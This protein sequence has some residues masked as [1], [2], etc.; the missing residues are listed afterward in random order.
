MK[1][2]QLFTILVS[3]LIVGCSTENYDIQENDVYLKNLEVSTRCAGSSYELIDGDHK[4][5]RVVVTNNNSMTTAYVKFIAAEG[6]SITAI[7]SGYARDF[8]GLPLSNGGIIPGKLI[9]TD[10]DMTKEVLTTYDIHGLGFVYAARVY[11]VS[12]TGLK[13]SVWLGSLEAGKNGSKYIS[14]QPCGNVEDIPCYVNSDKFVTL[15]NSYVR[16]NLYGY[17][18]LRNYYLSLL[19]EGVSKE[20]TFSPN[21]YSLVESYKENN[22]QSFT[23]KYTITEADCSEHVYLS[24]TVVP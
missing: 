7:R 15:T 13:Y 17:T 2:H 5:A 21:V 23:T 6:Y 9:K 19:D 24:I 16:E 20:G 12:N 3:I 22:F 8:N 11:M 18:L 1:Y 4:L 14:Y 10:Y